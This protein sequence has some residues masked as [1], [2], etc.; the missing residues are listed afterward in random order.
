MTDKIYD[1]IIIG[2]GPG[3]LTAAIYALRAKLDL[4]L[5]EKT[6]IGGQIALSDVV[7]NY[8]G[9]PGL[10][11]VELM[12]KFEEQ[13][14]SFG[15]QTDY[16]EV[17]SIKD[18]GDHRL[19]STTSGG[20][21][22]RAVIIA[23]GAK[24]RR[25]NVP[26]ETE[27]TG[28][29]VSYCAT[30]DGFFFR[31]KDVVVVGGGDTAV[32]ESLFLAKLVNKVTVIHRRDA[33]RAEKIIQEKALADPKI[34]FLWDTVVER[35]SGEKTVSGV[36][37]KNIKTDETKDLA[38]DGAFVFVGI[39]PNSDFID[40]DKDEAG[41]IRTDDHMRTS[42]N[43]VFAVGDVRTTVL[44]QVATAVGDGAIAAHVAGE[45]IESL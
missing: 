39:L 11:G 35:I 27:Y 24:P 26:G 43:G 16:A 37:V 22:T 7:E 25:L 12:T 20:L 45:F 40:C 18:H 44:R 36:T 29:G 1:L 32:K 5:L 17:Q 2:G 19:V 21:K 38:V 41:F 13:A 6:G 42:I 3:G 31:G 15:L 34:D 8:P 23:A 9:L 30:C 33:L 28:R 4:L 10:S 14:K